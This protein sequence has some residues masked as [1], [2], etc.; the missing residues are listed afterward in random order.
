MA[1]GGVS[2]LTPPRKPSG[3]P[4][5]FTTGCRGSG[6]SV[7]R[8]LSGGRDA[9]GEQRARQVGEQVAAVDFSSPVGAPRGAVA[10]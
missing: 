3:I 9:A 5:A 10:I 1:G 2:R 8:V 6:W 4:G 7:L